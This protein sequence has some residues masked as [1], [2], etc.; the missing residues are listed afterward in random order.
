MLHDVMLAYEMD[1]KPLAREHGA[2]VRVV[3]PEMYG[4]K[5]VK[6]V[7]RIVVGDAIEPGYWEQR[8]YDV[9]AWVG[10]LEWLLSQRY[11]RRFSRTERA[12]HWVHASAFFVLLASGLVLYVPRLE[13]A[14]R[15]P[16]AG[17]GRPHLHGARLAAS[18]SRSSS[19]SA[20]AGAAPDAARARRLRR[21]DRLLAAADPAARRAASTPGRS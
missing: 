6:W 8:G 3:I 18:R 13:R 11:V 7:E 21:D 4:Y 20:T 15:P 16:A 17:Q 10:R 9:D 12:L 1:G 5:N 2:P 14:R 19:C